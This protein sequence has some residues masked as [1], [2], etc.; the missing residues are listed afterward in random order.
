MP[1]PDSYANSNL[2]WAEVVGQLSN[3]SN[4]WLSST[5]PDGRPHSIMAGSLWLED[6]Y[7]QP[8]LLVFH[9]EPQSQT[10]QNLTARPFVVVHLEKS[11][12]ATIVIVEG[13][14]ERLT[15]AATLK[16]VDGAFAAK[17]NMPPAANQTAKLV[18]SLR[19]TQI[20][21]W[22]DDDYKAQ[23][24][25]QW[26]VSLPV[27]SAPAKPTAVPPQP[28]TDSNN[29]GSNV[30]PYSA[31]QVHEDT[32]EIWHE[33]FGVIWP[34]RVHLFS[35]PLHNVPTGGY[36][37]LAVSPGK[38]LGNVSYYRAFLE[39]VTRKGYIVL[40]VVTEADVL[41]CQHERMAGEFLNAVKDAITNHFDPG[42]LANGKIGWWGHS[43]GSKVTAIAT[44]LTTHPDYIQPTFVIGT[45]FT[46]AKAF[47]QAD[48][49]AN[50][51]IIPPQIAY[52]LLP[53]SNDT[54]AAPAESLT[55]YNAMPQLKRRQVI[56]VNGYTPDG[57]VADHAA[58]MSAGTIPL[59]RLHGEVNALDW[60]GYWKFTVGAL[61]F[62]FKAGSDQ[63][64]YGAKRLYG[65]TDSTGHQLLY[66]QLA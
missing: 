18:Y 40:F 4:Y 36:A 30:Y 15:D 65:G 43:M 21:V 6:S 2:A 17:Y 46:N 24:T 52:T 13:L 28:P 57:L 48:A 1:V 9:F 54:I 55:L 10:V 39:H 59:T 33:E 32:W 12:S 34:T 31:A 56:Q 11:T 38:E 8:G 49:Y 42:T 41:D 29:P 63:W 50:A 7:Q 60:Y 22:R 16:R 26:N 14:I 62:H 37:M 47:C 20:R 58:P 27:P 35:P 61:D 53:G 25:W 3:S 23:N 64:I 51:H 19:P 66:T 44:S 5:L 45:A